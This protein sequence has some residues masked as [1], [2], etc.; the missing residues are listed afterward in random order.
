MPSSF[1]KVLGN[2]EKKCN[3]IRKDYMWCSKLRTALVNE[4]SFTKA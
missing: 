2:E 3:Y 1:K 4:L